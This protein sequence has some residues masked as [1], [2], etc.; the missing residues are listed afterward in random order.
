[1]QM[2][3]EGLLSSLP[4]FHCFRDSQKRENG[5]G[6]VEGHVEHFFGIHELIVRNLGRNYGVI[7]QPARVCEMQIARLRG[8]TA[9]QHSN[10]VRVGGSQSIKLE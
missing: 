5:A 1:M 2:S 9:V 3:P 6:G 10:G 4:A 8:A 7:R